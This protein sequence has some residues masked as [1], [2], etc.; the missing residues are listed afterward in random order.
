MAAEHGGPCTALKRLLK[1]VTPRD[2]L[3]DRWPLCLPALLCQ[4]V[5]ELTLATTLIRHSKHHETFTFTT[6]DRTLAV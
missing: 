1:Q 5:S 6:I 3:H 2:V 4:P